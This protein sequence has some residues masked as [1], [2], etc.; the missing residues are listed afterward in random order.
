M[1]A[2]GPEADTACWCT[3][4]VRSYAFTDRDG[5]QR[6]TNCSGLRDPKA[7]IDAARPDHSRFAERQRMSRNDLDDPEDDRAF[8]EMRSLMRYGR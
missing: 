1:G 7:A 2:Y 6:C 8:R 4:S 3:G 5:R